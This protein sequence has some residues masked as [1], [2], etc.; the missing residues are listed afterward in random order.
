M[1]QSA[2]PEAQLLPHQAPKPTEKAAPWEQPGAHRRPYR[3]LLA[4]LAVVVLT[5]DSPAIAD[6]GPAGGFRDERARVAQGP[7]QWGVLSGST[8]RETLESW[9]EA[10]G[11]SV[12]WDSELDYRL[13]A[14]SKYRGSYTTAV[15]ALADSV[16]RTNPEL[17]IT[18]YTGNKVV[19]VQTI[20]SETK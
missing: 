1:Q 20:L 11:W 2:K 4:V 14:S 13:R 12:V 17:T 10:A 9:S 8:L 19:H 16:H 15:Q 6:A 5:T 3:V 18:L 7:D